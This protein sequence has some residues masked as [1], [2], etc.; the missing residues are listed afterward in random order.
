MCGSAET[1]AQGQMSDRVSATVRSKIMAAV[2]TKNTGPEVAVQRMLHR[3]PVKPPARGPDPAAR[4]RAVVASL[5]V[6][7]AALW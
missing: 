2:Q 3:L 1:V 5:P 6:V 4:L 7:Q